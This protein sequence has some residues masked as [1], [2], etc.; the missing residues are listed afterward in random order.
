MNVYPSY[1]INYGSGAT[2]SGT[3]TDDPID[4]P[5]QG[6]LMAHDLQIYISPI[7]ITVNNQDK[8]V[9]Q[10]SQTYTYSAD[11]GYS[12]IGSITVTAQ[13]ANPA[14]KG[15]DAH[16]SADFSHSETNVT[17]TDTDTGIYI[18]PDVSV[19][20]SRASVLYNGA[21]NG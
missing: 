2:K 8:N 13:T 11:S 17:T 5:T 21:V 14:F 6:K 15:G 16:A 12:G 3:A 9:T 20:Y 19:D 7:D 18:Q 4:L 10:T 1:T